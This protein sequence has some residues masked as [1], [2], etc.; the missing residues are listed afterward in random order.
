MMDGWIG[1]QMRDGWIGRW[2]DGWMDRL[3]GVDGYIN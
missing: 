3:G 2:I 1:R